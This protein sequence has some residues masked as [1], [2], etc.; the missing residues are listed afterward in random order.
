MLDCCEL[1]D[2]IKE[3]GITLH[4]LACVATCNGA[5]VHLHYGPDLTVEEFRRLI[6]ISCSRCCGVK[7]VLI[8]SYARWDQDGRMACCALLCCA[9]LCDAVVCCAMLKLQ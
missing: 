3:K 5:D 4:K 9:V 6:Q 7:T 1:L 8:A 2:T